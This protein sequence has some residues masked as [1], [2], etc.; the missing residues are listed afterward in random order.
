MTSLKEKLLAKGK[1]QLKQINIQFPD[2]EDFQAY[3]KPYTA[4][5]YQDS[6]AFMKSLVTEKDGKEVVDYGRLREASAYSI[7]RM[8]VDEH[9]S[10]LVTLDEVLSLS[11]DVVELIDKAI[12]SQAPNPEQSAKK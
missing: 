5:E 6:V 3:I 11:D 12:K 8:L 7:S 9:G 2:G 10:P 1:V 4:K